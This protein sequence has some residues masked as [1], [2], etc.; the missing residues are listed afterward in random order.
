MRKNPLPPLVLSMLALT[1]I[2][3]SSPA[4]A[5]A[6]ENGFSRANARAKERVT[7]M[8]KSATPAA[9]LQRACE[10]RE[11]AVVKRMSQLVLLSN[12]MLANFEAHS[13]RVQNY[14]LNKVVPAGLVVS[15]YDALLADIAAKKAVVQTAVANAQA[16]VNDFSCTTGEPKSYL[17][18]YR[19]NMQETK[20]ALK[21]Y[22]TAVK[23]LIVA[24]ST[25]AEGLEEEEDD[26][27]SPKPSASPSP[28]VTPTPSPS[29][30]I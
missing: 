7:R 5:S 13:T 25:V 10:V 23:N 12:K 2:L 18:S 20:T 16:D 9:S 15:N 19:V 26:D 4:L 22:R 8:M 24:V 21:N 17:N 11:S 14:Y 1:L 30:S 6:Q 27:E 3:M 28:V 29:P